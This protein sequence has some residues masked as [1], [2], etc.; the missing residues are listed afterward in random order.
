MWLATLTSIAL[1]APPELPEPPELS[2]L[3]ED[4]APEVGP[5]PEA[6]AQAPRLGEYIRT[7][8]K[9]GW[10]QVLETWTPQQQAPY[11]PATSGAPTAE[12][13]FRGREHWEK[14]GALQDLL[15]L[16]D[17]T[18]RVLASDGRQL[19][20]VRLRAGRGM[21]ALP[22]LPGQ[23][24]WAAVIDPE[25]GLPSSPVV[26]VAI[27]GPACRW[28]QDQEGYELALAEGRLGHAWQLHQR[29]GA[30]SGRAGRLE[31]LCRAVEEQPEATDAL[32]VWLR[33]RREGV[34]TTSRVV[35]RM[36]S[37]SLHGFEQWRAALDGLVGD[38]VGADEI[39][40]YCEAL[41]I[42]VQTLSLEERAEL[43]LRGV[44]SRAPYLH[45]RHPDLDAC[46]L[47]PFEALTVET[48]ELACAAWR[49]GVA[50]DDLVARFWLAN[51]AAEAQ[52][53]PVEGRQHPTSLSEPGI[54]KI[55]A[56][57]QA[58]LVSAHPE[59]RW[60]TE[61]RADQRARAE[62]ALCADISDA[63]NGDTRFWETEPNRE[64]GIQPSDVN[65]KNSLLLERLARTAA[66]SC[67]RD[68]ARATLDRHRETLLTQGRSVRAY[69]D[70]E[71]LE[72]LR[73][74]AENF[75]KYGRRHSLPTFPGLHEGAEWELLVGSTQRRLLERFK[76]GCLQGRIEQAECTRAAQAMF[77]GESWEVPLP[78][79]VVD[80]PEHLDRFCRETVR[81]LQAPRSVQSVRIADIE[82]SD[83]VL[84]D[85]TD[86][87][88]Q[89][90]W[91]RLR[92][93]LP[94]MFAEDI[95]VEMSNLS[96][97]WLATTCSAERMERS[98][99]HCWLSMEQCVQEVAGFCR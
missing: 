82:W 99:K 68:C 12:V 33:L 63:W 96:L 61:L 46:F 21:G 41:A 66:S 19:G 51:L 90:L 32:G 64:R 77:G 43:L 94:A 80:A 88:I 93:E 10:Y 53:P 16:D 78:G 87:E 26:E 20:E 28:M 4:P 24:G 76:Q 50:E 54:I 47:P 3:P 15:S 13:A 35:P 23:V 86:D 91:P 45:Y 75:L 22:C 11:D 85:T 18:V 56:S 57:G 62:L 70:A 98:A 29:L 95:C 48:Y 97:G 17:A 6:F 81:P 84:W 74:M 30:D 59:L 92:S 37:A 73:E 5:V 9:H 40:P 55:A 36:L 1:A 8:G 58:S 44:G 14:K 39:R 49:D 65:V 60:F 7:K 67:A 38:E 69:E 25:T 34:C 2:A 89:R 72:A 79:W 83:Q 52:W 27:E 42:E 71:A 31:Q